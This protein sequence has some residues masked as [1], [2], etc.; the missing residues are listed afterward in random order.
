MAL[1]GSI[2]K[3]RM[4]SMRINNVVSVAFTPIL[5]FNPVDPLNTLHKLW[6]ECDKM[7]RLCSDP[8]LKTRLG[9]TSPAGQPP[10]TFT[11]KIHVNAR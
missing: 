6:I 3:K 7:L 5:G 1:L 4:T 2:L 9:V 8:D 11:Y 10:C